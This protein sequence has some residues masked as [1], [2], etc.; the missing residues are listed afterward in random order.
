MKEEPKPQPNQPEISSQ[1]A[2]KPV[3]DMDGFVER[4]QRNI[5]MA[6]KNKAKLITHLS[7]IVNKDAI[8]LTLSETS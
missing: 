5:A 6:A 8:G 4:M 3:Q 1:I 2:N 7:E